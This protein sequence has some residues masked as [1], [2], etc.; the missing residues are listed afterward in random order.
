MGTI[1]I[2]TLDPDRLA[3]WNYLFTEQERRYIPAPYDGLPLLGGW[4]GKKNS[5]NWRKS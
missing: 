5:A 1:L 3:G 4:F 2:Y